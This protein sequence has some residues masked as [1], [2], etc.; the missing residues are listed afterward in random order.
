MCGTGNSSGWKTGGGGSSASC[1]VEDRFVRDASYEAQQVFRTRDEAHPGVAR[2]YAESRV[3]LGGEIWLL[4]PS[5]EAEATGGEGL[6]ARYGLTPMETRAEFGRRGWRRVVGFQ[7]RNPVHRAH[8]YIQ[9]CALETV[10]GM[11]LHP[12]VGET[13]ADDVPAAVR[14]KSYETLLDTTIPRNVSCWPRFRRPCATQGPGRPSF[15]PCAGK[16]TAA[17]ILSSG[18]IMPA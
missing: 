10:D 2:L 1:R 18:G 8:E 13:K 4:P 7:T 11:L 6:L 14:M 17:H 3:L 16:T 5:P 12:L 9:K 15:T